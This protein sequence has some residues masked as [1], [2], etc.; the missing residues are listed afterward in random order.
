MP[1][2]VSDMDNIDPPAIT[3][4][5]RV[6]ETVTASPG[7]YNPVPD[8]VVYQWLADGDPIAGAT[9]AAF[10]VTP[11]VFGKRLSV[12][13]TAAKAGY[14]S[15]TIG[16]DETAEVAAGNLGVT[17]KPTISG[18]AKPGQTLTASMSGVNVTPNPDAARISYIWFRDGAPIV[19]TT[20]AQYVVTGE[21][22]GAKITVRAVIHA[23]G[24][25]DA[26]T[27][28][29][30]PTGAVARDTIT[31]LKDPTLKYFSQVQSLR[32]IKGDRAKV[33]RELQADLVGVFSVWPNS[34][35]VTWY[36][37]TRGARTV[38]SDKDINYRPSADDV[39]SLI[40]AVITTDEP[41]YDQATATTQKVRVVRASRVV[42]AAP[43]VVPVKN[44][45]KR[46]R[47]GALVKVGSK[48]RFIP[49]SAVT[50]QWYS[51][52]RRIAGAVGRTYRAI[53]KD[54]GK[55]LW[56]VAKARGTDAFKASIVR[57]NKTKPVKAVKG[58]G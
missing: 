46:P 49:T 12:L 17:G 44:K 32:K 18:V 35:K 33:G 10:S 28:T 40:W 42:Y 5:P 11:E 9:S 23:D 8:S 54:V 26:E 1:V 20:G 19:G 37:S 24:F 27:E 58:L 7:T 34:P 43:V 15:M 31:T 22:V 14:T 52:D 36:R 53:P 21:D 25:D 56:V 48:A 50:Y 47:A 55:R 45:E 3:G 2:V 16:T 51:G 13:V 41:G 30:E 39:G 6:G 38:I 57:S 29:S 4:T